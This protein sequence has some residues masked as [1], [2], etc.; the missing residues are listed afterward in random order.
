MKT[1]LIDD[2]AT[3]QAQEQSACQDRRRKAGIE[4]ARLLGN[5]DGAKPGD[6]KRLEAVAKILGKGAGD[7]HADAEALGAY[8]RMEARAGLA[9]ELTVE[10]NEAQAAL[11]AAREKLTEETARLQ[12]AAKQADLATTAAE[13]R[14]GAAYNARDSLAGVRQ[15]LEQ[16]GI[17]IATEENL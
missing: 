2:F 17:I 16:R 9:A 15:Q 6:V 5:A 8:R 11:V 1:N 12:E 13:N 3:R 4:Y 10:A 7:M 14:R